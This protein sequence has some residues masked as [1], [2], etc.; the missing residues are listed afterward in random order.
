[1][2]IIDTSILFWGR[3]LAAKY[4]VIKLPTAIAKRLATTSK[5][6]HFRYEFTSKQQLYCTE[7]IVST[8]MHCL[9]F[10]D[11]YLC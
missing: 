5:L 3:H 1:M 8:L 4:Y 2:R 7:C 10:T 6:R 9:P 11:V